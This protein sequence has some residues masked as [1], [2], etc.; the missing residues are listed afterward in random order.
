M[1]HCPHIMKNGKMFSI[2]L[3]VI[4]FYS[5]KTIKRKRQH[6]HH[7]C[8]QYFVDLN[9]LNSHWSIEK[10]AI[11]TQRMFNIFYIRSSHLCIIFAYAKY[12]RFQ[13]SVYKNTDSMQGFLAYFLSKWKTH[14][15][16]R[17]INNTHT[18]HS[19]KPTVSFIDNSNIHTIS[20]MGLLFSRLYAVHCTLNRISWF[21]F[22]FTM[23]TYRRKCLHSFTKQ[24]DSKYRPKH[25]KLFTNGQWAMGFV[26]IIVKSVYC[27]YVWMLDV[28]KNHKM[29]LF[30]YGE[31]TE[32]HCA[33]CQWTFGCEIFVYLFS[34]SFFS[35][36]EV[37]CVNSEQWTENRHIMFASFLSDFSIRPKI[38]HFICI[39]IK[40]SLIL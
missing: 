39:K 4:A 23:I 24:F 10:N 11:F 28:R 1:W 19:L 36:G 25:S 31:P 2:C 32:I 15:E 16:K 5:R 12:A 37:I 6:W 27:V 35:F 21:G 18:Q 7:Y 13:I 38:V 14:I 33:L 9:T 30:D 20:P 22:C 17:K 3:F 26:A 8:F 29:K 40:F 34:S